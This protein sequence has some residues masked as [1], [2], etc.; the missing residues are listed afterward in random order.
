[1]TDSRQRFGR[2]LRLGLIGGAPGTWIANMHR[3]AAELDG[4]WRVVAG[5]FSSDPGRSRAAG[6]ALGVEPARSYGDVAEMFVRERARDNG[7]DAVAI[8]TPNDTHYR[9]SAAALD[10]GLDVVCDKPVAG[11]FREA[12]DL[13]ARSRD[14]ARL[15]AIAHGYSAYPMIRHARWAR[16]RG[17][18]R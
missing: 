7:I 14:G 18:A 4:W 1:M 9:F 12:C 10:A 8:V 5:T 16:G 11:D 2:P 13:V 17:R 15:F 3:T 6:L